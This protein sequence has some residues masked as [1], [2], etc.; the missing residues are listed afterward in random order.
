MKLNDMSTEYLDLV[1][2]GRNEWWR[3]ALGIVL[4]IS[5]W[6]GVTIFTYV[7]VGIW[8]VV[9]S[10][11][12]TFINQTTGSIEGLDPFVTYILL[13][14]GHM[15]M[16]LGLFLA[17]RLLHGR[18]L[19]S[20]VTPRKRIDWRLMGLGFGLFFLLLIAF[21]FVEYFRDPSTYHLT[22]D[23]LRLLA[24]A[25]IVLILT[26]IQTTTEELV[27]RGY[28][29]QGCSLL[30]RRFAFPAIFSSLLFTS[31]HLGNPEL[32]H[33]YWQ[34]LLYYFGIGLLLAVIT[35][36]SNGLEL[37]IGVHA[38]VNLFSALVV[39][40][41]DSA[42]KTESIFI[43]TQI[44]ASLNLV[45]FAILAVVFYYLLFG[46]KLEQRVRSG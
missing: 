4:T 45:L 36:R 1:H 8:L 33:G 35:V 28:L 46:L 22:G 38:S 42:L 44:D 30:T 5:L 3:Y 26:P 34:V 2:E 6:L 43:C 10:N 23:P 24:L 7:L 19:L 21:T 39:N 12:E 41:S 27:F 9:D 25:P 29:L 20:L 31:M 15:A 32:G 13:N 40:Y 18:P 37:A 17:V 16:L 14:I 11:P